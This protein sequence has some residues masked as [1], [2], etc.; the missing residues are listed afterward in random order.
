MIPM[1]R[2]ANALANNG[3][4]VSL[5]G[6]D[7]TGEFVKKVLRAPSLPF[8]VCEMGPSYFHHFKFDPETTEDKLAQVSGNFMCVLTQN[9]FSSF[10]NQGWI[11]RNHF[12]IPEAIATFEYLRDHIFYR[13]SSS[14]IAEESCNGGKMPD[15]VV[16]DIFSYGGVMLMKD[17]PNVPHVINDPHGVL[18]DGSDPWW[19]PKAHVTKDPYNLSVLD[20]IEN[21]YASLQYDTVFH[22]YFVSLASLTWNLRPSLRVLYNDPS[23]LNLVRKSRGLPPMSLDDMLGRFAHMVL[24]N[25]AFGLEYP[26]PFN[27]RV[28]FVGSLAES[29]NPFDCCT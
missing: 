10:A 20:I 7:G 18:E 1:V 26:R 12:L 11:R 21:I 3:A 4:Q 17:F 15:A 29:S 24:A 14:P 9:S 6:M 22:I 16:S 13:A 19:F 5:A 28:Q 25:T 2:I 23:A 8:N 27:A